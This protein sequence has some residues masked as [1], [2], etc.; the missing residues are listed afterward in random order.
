MSALA[1]LLTG[2]IDYAGLF[3][4]AACSMDD[5]VAEYAAQRGGSAAFALGRFVLPVA[6]LDAFIGAAAPRIGTDRWTLAVLGGAEDDAAIRAFNERHGTVAR[7]DTVE[8]KATSV[9]AIA[10]LA[11]LDEALTVYVEVP[12]AD[13]PTPLIEAIA[14]HG[15]RAKVRTGGVVATAVPSSAD[16]ARFLV[17]CVQAQVPCK[18]T[19]GL[20]HAVCGS[21]PLTYA[22]DA[23]QGTLFGFLNVAV[24]AVLARRGAD[25][26]QVAAALEETDPTQFRADATRLQWRDALMHIS[27]LR[28]GDGEPVLPFGSCSFADPIGELRTLGLL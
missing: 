27:A 17:A 2:A 24:A 28:D 21:Y 4:P 20:H 19:A 12:V 5:A 26:D 7:I 8:G 11:T 10:A 6:Q 23:P 25:V 22:A 9:E 15:L 1:A 3:P 14:A 18:A 13:D 16:V